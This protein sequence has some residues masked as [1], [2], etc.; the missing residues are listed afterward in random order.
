[1]KQIW[2]LAAYVYVFLLI[3]SVVCFLTLIC[4]IDS[5]FM[6]VWKKI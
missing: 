2:T 1:M 3:K 5:F 4:Y 6:N